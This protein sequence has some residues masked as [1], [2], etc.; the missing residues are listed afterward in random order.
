MLKNSIIVIV[1]TAI[2][3]VAIYAIDTG[4]SLG[5]KGIKKLANNVSVSQEAEENAPETELVE[6]NAE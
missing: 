4:L 3:G 5:M 6:D 2:V 1:V